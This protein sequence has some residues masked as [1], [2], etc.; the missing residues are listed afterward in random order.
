MAWGAD[1]GTK[2][3]VLQAVAGSASELLYIPEGLATLGFV[4]SRDLVQQPTPTSAHCG[5]IVL[6]EWIKTGD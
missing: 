5:L 3:K 4:C 2:Y 1:N 6:V